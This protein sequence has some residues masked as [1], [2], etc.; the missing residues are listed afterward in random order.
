MTRCGGPARS[1]ACRTCSKLCSLAFVAYCH[2][3][4]A[5]SCDDQITLDRRVDA[6]LEA[7]V[8]RRVTNVQGVRREQVAQIAATCNQVVPG[9]ADGAAGSQRRAPDGQRG[10]E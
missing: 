4:S 10:C 9:N 3:R 6:M 7:E 8:G 5:R 2:G 1:T